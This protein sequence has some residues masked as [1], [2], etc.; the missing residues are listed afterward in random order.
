MPGILC[1]HCTAACCR[2]IALPLDTPETHAEFEDLRWFL[3]HEQV[4]IFVEDGDWYIAMQT[5]CRHLQP[6][7]RCGIYDTRPKICR[8]YTTENCDYH[9][10]D[11]G[12][13]HHFTSA[14]HLDEY[15]RE[16]PLGLNGKPHK[17]R[18]QA[19][20]RAGSKV[21]PS[22][23]RAAGRPGLKV[24]PSRRRKRPPAPAQFDRRGV[25]LPVLPWTNTSP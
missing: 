10:G 25:P 21:D 22:R 9:S 18:R 13:E 5:P 11:Y 20:P 6:D 12:W 7:H 3:L 8:A 16:H 14:A 2:Y 1:E 4:S 23:S 17:R 15:L 24:N 19:P